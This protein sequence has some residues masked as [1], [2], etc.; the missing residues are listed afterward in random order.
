MDVKELY[1]LFE[2]MYFYEIDKKDKFIAKLNIPFAAIVALVGYYAFLLSADRAGLGFG[3]QSLFWT[4]LFFS[5]FCT[6][7]AALFFIRALLGGMDKA[8][9]TANEIEEYRQ[10]LIKH[11]EGYEG[12][13]RFVSEQLKLVMY[14]NY[15]S[16]STIITLNNERKGYDYFYCNLFLVFSSVSGLACYVL[17]ALLSK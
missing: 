6:M 8:I 11:Y 7:A 14:R 13:E 12:A 10:S 1:E 16:C 9:L 2:K 4:V 17:M 3:F 15:M 5:I